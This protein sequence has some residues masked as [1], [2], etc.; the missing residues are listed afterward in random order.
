MMLVTNLLLMAAAAGSAAS[1]RPVQP[2][3]EDSALVEAYD[4]CLVAAA[5]EVPS[6]QEARSTL[7]A[8]AEADCRATLRTR[9]DSGEFVDVGKAGSSRRARSEGVLDY[10]DAR[11]DSMIMT[12][13]DPAEVNARIAA[14]GIGVRVYQPVAAQ[15]GR[16]TN[17]V[18]AAFQS[19]ELPAANTAPARVKAWRDAIRSCRGLK[20][21]MIKESDSILAHRADFQDPGTRRSAISE[22]FDGYDRMMLKMAETDWTRPQNNEARR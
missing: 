16:Y 12:M 3:A 10:V 6:G 21:A 5:R 9:M 17:C 20:A 2:M 19:G 22:M 4:R 14:M 7:I 15:H 8:K 13:A 11:F 1:A 18:T